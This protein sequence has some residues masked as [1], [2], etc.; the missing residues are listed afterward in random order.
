V[1]DVALFGMELSISGK[2]EIQSA[3]THHVSKPFGPYNIEFLFVVKDAPSGSVGGEIDAIGDPSRRFPTVVVIPA[4]VFHDASVLGWNG[5]RILSFVSDG[6]KERFKKSYMSV[7]AVR[8]EMVRECSKAQLV[9]D[10]SLIDAQIILD[11]T[12]APVRQVLGIVVDLKTVSIR[13]ATTR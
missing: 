13:P 12:V 4:K 10:T 6:A 3:L 8:L 9:K 1:H 2:H 7:D 11:F 5:H